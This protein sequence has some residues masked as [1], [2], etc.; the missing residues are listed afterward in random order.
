MKKIDLSAVA[1]GYPSSY[2][3]PF[4]EP[5]N[6]QICQRL[7]RSQGLSLFGVNLTVIAP[8]GWSSQRHWHSHE[9]EFV[10]VLEGEL[11]LVTDAGEELLHAGDCAAFRRGDPDGHHLVNKSSRPATVLEIGNSDPQDRCVYSDIDMIAGPGV[12]RYTH[13][14]GIPY[15]LKK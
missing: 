11:I 15:P 8:G 1:V 13:R 6:S 5:C 2:P 4:D 10:W 7:G 12:T 9:D 3:P 14:D